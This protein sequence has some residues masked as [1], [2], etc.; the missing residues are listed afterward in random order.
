MGIFKVKNKRSILTLVIII[1]L[2]EGVG[3][4]SGYLG[5][6][7]PET[8]KNFVKP[9]FSP[10]SWVFGIVWMI[11]YILMAFAFYRIC[12]LGREGENI[13]KAL[14]LY[15]FQ[16]ILNF[17]WTIIFFRFRL[18]GLAFIELMLLIV[19]VMLTTFEFFRLNKFAGLIMIPYILW[20]CFAGVLNFSF[21]MLNNV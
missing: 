9:A 11:L 15:A 3:I 14:T 20:I 8:Y 21:W 5:M 19:F 1:L 6:S 18:I 16:L 10:P 17:L 12:M 7:N 13:I 2:T 4:L